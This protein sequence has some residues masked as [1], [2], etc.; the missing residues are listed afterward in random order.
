[1]GKK[2]RDNKENEHIEEEKMNENSSNTNKMIE[3]LT[4]KIEDLKSI[5]EA[6]VVNTHSKNQKHYIHEFHSKNNIGNI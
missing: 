6:L 2:S 4:A 3:D 1:M 5:T